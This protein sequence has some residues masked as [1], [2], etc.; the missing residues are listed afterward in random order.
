[1]LIS[2][3][4]TLYCSS[5]TIEA[6]IERMSASA[7]QVTQDY[8]IV[9]VNDGSPDDALDKAVAAQQLDKHIKVIDLSRNFGHH[10]AGMVGIEYSQGDYV[11]LIDSDLEEAPELFSKFWQEMQARKNS[12]VIYGMQ[13]QRKGGRFEQFSGVLFYKLFN[14]LSDI[15]VS[16][17]ILTIRLMN[18]QYVDT[19]K[20]Y[21]EK[22]LFVSGIMAHAG[23]TQ[24]PLI[25]AKKSKEGTTYTLAKR[26][27]LLIV[28]MTSFS[29]KL[30]SYIFTVGCFIL[31]FSISLAL[32]FYAHYM[33]TD[34]VISST[35][36]VLLAT[37]GIIGSITACTGLL[38]FY[39]S[40]IYTEVRQRPRAI[41]KKIYH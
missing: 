10:E 19:I 39:I 38:G 7:Q 23:F 14:H 18:R 15:K 28:C 11:F 17:N 33:I 40:A 24:T 34:E 22:N 20:Q 26:L 4:T 16:P 13:E 25:V 32:Y 6:F 9:I 2:I 1:M 31:L 35:K 12:D 8:E 21:Q 5:A 3:V 37:G 36:T 27:Q 29:S 30:L 41:I